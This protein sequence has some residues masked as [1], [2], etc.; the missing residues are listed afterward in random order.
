MSTV[1]ASL[2]SSELALGRRAV[3]Q[4]ERWARE[5]PQGLHF[6]RIPLG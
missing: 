4:W 3:A 5:V 2:A 1:P 6:G